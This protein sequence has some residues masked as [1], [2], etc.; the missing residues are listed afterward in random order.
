M[1]FAIT[2]A[3]ASV[4]STFGLYSV[5]PLVLFNF[6]FFGAGIVLLTFVYA[7]RRDRMPAGLE[8]KQLSIFGALNTTIYLGLFVLAL[9]EVTPG[10]T[11]LA[12]SLNPLF[13]S[14]LSA[15]WGKRTVLRREWAGVFIGMGGVLLAAWP[16]LETNL[17]SVRGLILIGLSQV[18]YSIGAVY[19]ANVKWAL[20]RTA[21]NGW[22]AFLGGV[23]LL[24]FTWL[25]HHEPNTF[26]LRF[27]LSLAWLVIPVSVVAIQLWL[28]MVEKDAV[29]ASMWLYLCPVFGFLYAAALVNEPLSL[30]TLSGTALVL[31]ALY[32]GTRK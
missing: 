31:W 6:R 22:Q 19:F 16:H 13:I 1:S 32:L 8:W 27:F 3:S 4:A 23:F 14:I 7:L 24:P 2:W 21:I 28:K 11:T 18:A 12:I 30:Y 25:L 20:S 15:V 26:D 9:A 29:R 17:A 10:I 5:E